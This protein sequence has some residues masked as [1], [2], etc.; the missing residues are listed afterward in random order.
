MGPTGRASSK[1][2]ENL[3]RDP[4]DL[5][6]AGMEVIFSL[7]NG[8]QGYYLA[9]AQGD[10]LDSA[11]TEIV[12]DRNAA[13]HVVRNGLSCLRCHDEGTK[14]FADAVRPAVEKLPDAPGFDRARVL[15][16]YPPQ[17]EMDRLLEADAGRFRDALARA[18]GHFPARDPLTPVSR[19][20]LDAPLTLAQAAA[21][22]GHP[23]PEALRPAFASGPLAALGLPA[24]ASGGE[25]RRDAWEHAFDRVVRHLGL[26]EPIVPLDSLT[27]RDLRP[28][29]TYLD[30]ELK[31]NHPNG[32][33]TPG[34]ELV[35]TVSNPTGKP[36]HVE[37]IGTDAR[38]RKVLLTPGPV[39]IPAGGT[40]R[41]PEQGAI[42]IQ[43]QAGRE[44]ITLFASDRPFPPG[45]L[46]RGQDVA[47][48]VV[49][50]HP[51]V[52]RGE[53]SFDPVHIIKK[54]IDIETR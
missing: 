25:V 44:R 45:E 4:I 26:G 50:P 41:Y 53:V 14:G 29:S 8:L 43:P 30:V 20:F 42:T 3:F 32:L 38:G 6:P 5:T 13:D 12:A 24:L 23:S 47:D 21:E 1:A 2:E 39:P 19:R 54:T 18:L 52:R 35:I 9:D 31:T 11:P 34:D 28:D 48:R 46:L 37:L 27:R 51:T 16:A 15:R 40:Y 7:P 36:L 22:L 17:A 49:H 10:R 33:F